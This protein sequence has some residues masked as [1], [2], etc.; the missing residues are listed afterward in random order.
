MTFERSIKARKSNQEICI[1]AK[2]GTEL[3]VGDEIKA[4]GNNERVSVYH[5]QEITETRPANL[6]G[7]TFIRAIS[8]WENRSLK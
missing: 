5:I 3:N 8:R 4:S 7:Y 2:N 6:K 1:Y